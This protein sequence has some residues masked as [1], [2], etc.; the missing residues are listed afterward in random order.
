MFVCRRQL[1]VSR[2]TI[3]CH[4]HQRSRQVHN[5]SGLARPCALSPPQPHA[6]CSAATAACPC[7][8]P[9]VS[10]RCVRWWAVPRAACA[11]GPFDCRC[12]SGPFPDTLWSGEAGTERGGGAEGSEMQR[13]VYQTWPVYL[14][15]GQREVPSPV[16][17]NPQ[18][19]WSLIGIR[20]VL[21]SGP[22]GLCTESRKDR[23]GRQGLQ[24]RIL[25]KA[26]P[27]GGST[28]RSAATYPSA[29]PPRPCPAGG[30]R[31]CAATPAA[32]RTPFSCRV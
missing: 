12:S 4:S 21:C 20:A 31:P 26:L 28:Y 30:R 3:P 8:S 17:A 13:L 29:T 24:G 22:T 23:T 27:P 7:R 1:E 9:P 5:R 10:F 15:L 16:A 25:T 18:G 11:G 6:V 19:P 32:G 2:G 14:D